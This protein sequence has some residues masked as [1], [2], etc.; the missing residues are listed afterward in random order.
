M[1]LIINRKPT[2][3]RNSTFSVITVVSVCLMAF[4]ASAQKTESSQHLR[5]GAMIHLEA[6]F[7]QNPQLRATN[8]QNQQQAVKRKQEYLSSPSPNR[9]GEEFS[10][11]TLTGPVYVPVVVHIVLPNALQITDQDVQKQ[12]DKLNIDYAGL[13][14]DSSNLPPAFKALFGKTKIQFM[15]ARR[16]PGGILTNGIDRRNS[17]TQS[18]LT[19]ATDPI[20]RFSQGGLDAWDFTK[21]L[22][23]WVG[24]DASGYGILGYATFPGTDIPANQG[25]FINALG[26]GNNT[27]YVIPA[28]G[29]GR[30]L[31]H[32][33]G[34]Y[35]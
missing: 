26:F 35:F 7:N 17:S 30:T 5:C 31:V 18:D 23:V 4:H 33:V 24:L 20:K 22:N 13:N 14:A 1:S 16:T 25:V 19:L 15:L 12:I 27:C 32:E 3:L 11:N 28:Y 21:Y 29:L 9:Q 2:A 6:L 10:M 34:H 8:E